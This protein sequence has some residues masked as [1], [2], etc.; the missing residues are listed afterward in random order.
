MNV[1]LWY[2]FIDESTLVPVGLYR[3]VLSHIGI[4]S[5]TSSKPANTQ[6]FKRLNV[7]TFQRKEPMTSSLPR[8]RGAP[9]GNF[10]GFKHGF[11]TTRVKKH[12]PSAEEVTDLKS[13]FDEIA[14]IRVF[15][16][17]LVES[18]DATPTRDELADILRILCLSSA[19]ITR[20]LRVHYLITGSENDLDP[21]IEEAIRQVQARLINKQAPTPIPASTE[22]DANLT[23]S[24]PHPQGED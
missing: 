10:N 15:T 11:Y 17:K 24:N 19:A 21:D 14:L 23:S 8:R 9:L 13:L 20:I 18:C 3:Y 22:Q 1:F 4:C 12:N 5:R 16:N 7:P 2:V 6:L